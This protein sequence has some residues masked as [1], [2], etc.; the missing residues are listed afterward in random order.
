MAQFDAKIFNAEVFGKYVERIPRVKQNKLLD[1][2]VLRPRGELKQLLADQTGGN[3]VTVPMLGLIDGE[4]QNYDGQ[5][6]IT[7]SGTKTYGQSMIV[8]GRAK[9]WTEKDFSADITATNFMDNVADQVSNYWQ[10]IDQDTLLS[11]LKG[12]FSMTGKANLPFVTGHTHDIS[13]KTGD[14][15]KVGA[16]TLNTAIQQAAGDNKGLFRLVICHSA[17]ATELENLSAVEYLK[18]TDAQGIVR[19]LGMA[20]WNGKMLLIDD[21]MPVEDVAAGYAL[22][23][24]AAIDPAKTY[25]TKSGSNYS[26]AA[27][28]VLG[29]I[30][31]YY[32]LHTSAY[33]AYT[34]YVLG[35]GAIDF[36][37]CGAKVPYEMWRDPKSHGGEDTLI[38]RQRKLFAPRGISFVK[39]AMASLSPTKP[40][41]E[42]GANWALVSDGAET[43]STI[44]HKAIPIARIISKG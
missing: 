8:V 22:T 15:A 42:S 34:S 40:E 4:A 25:Y 21:G 43:P 6:T 13:T 33:T 14:A 38:T 24:D 29:S 23:T 20:T 17:V 27:A 26:P 30:G 7:P 5:T 19:D 10:D 2:G 39:A 44:N 37:D 11:V 18:Y 41:L 36:C 12:I 1:A 31:T 35:D 3:Y 32:E 28:P 16:T 9:A